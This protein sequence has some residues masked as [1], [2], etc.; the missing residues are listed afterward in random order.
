MWSHIRHECDAWS[1]ARDVVMHCN[2]TSLVFYSSYPSHLI[3]S[4]HY[5]SDDNHSRCCLTNLYQSIC[6][7]FYQPLQLSLCWGYWP[8]RHVTRCDVS[9]HAPLPLSMNL[10]RQTSR[11]RSMTDTY[12]L[13]TC[14]HY[15][16]LHLLCM[17]LP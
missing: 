10:P 3:S 13:L 12:M 17:C 9:I 8:S 14:I 4:H 15:L 1:I 5:N 2:G 11:E 6:I 16:S 7:L